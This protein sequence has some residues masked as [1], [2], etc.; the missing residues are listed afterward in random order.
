MRILAATASLE[1]IVAA[2]TDAGN[3][4]LR[5]AGTH[6]NQNSGDS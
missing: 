6:A 5:R 4:R 1:I 2:E 3:A